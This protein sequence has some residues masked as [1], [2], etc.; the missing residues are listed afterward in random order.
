M[1][2]IEKKQCMIISCQQKDIACKFYDP[3][4]NYRCNLFQFAAE[5]QRS[6]I[7]T[8]TLETSETQVCHILCV[9]DFTLAIC[10]GAR[11]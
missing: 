11:L 4:L 10:F 8:L 6:G 7:R 3:Q 1:T 9:Q 5:F 2:F